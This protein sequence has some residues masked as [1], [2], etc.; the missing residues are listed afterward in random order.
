M[1]KLLGGVAMLASLSYGALITIDLNLPADGS[2]LDHYKATLLSVNLDSY[3]GA[4]TVIQSATLKF[5]DIQNLR[6]P[7][8]NDILHI[9][10]L[11]LKAPGIGQQNYN[12]YPDNQAISDYFK[13]NPNNNPQ[14]SYISGKSFV[15]TYTDNNDIGSWVETKTGVKAGT[16]YIAGGWYYVSYDGSK[17]QY[18][19][20]WKRVRNYTTEDFDRA[21]NV[22]VVNEFR[23]ASKGWI[24]IGLDADCHYIGKVS[25]VV[26][27][28]NVP[29]PASLSLFGLG[30]LS[31]LFF[32]RKKQ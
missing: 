10:L 6:E 24:G 28:K 26:E 11:K 15:G 16:Q 17:G 12:V 13:A 29:E 25:L 27:T 7:E 8:T 1:Y 19:G 5:D 20:I 30:L 4:G 23:T 14:Y 2:G 18:G 9:D 32:R 31:L 3:I 21:L 22:A